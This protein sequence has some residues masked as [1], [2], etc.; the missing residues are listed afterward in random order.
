MYMY[1]TKI[2]AFIYTYW[3][4]GPANLL[5]SWH[6]HLLVGG[7]EQLGHEAE[8]SCGGEQ[9]V[10]F[11]LPYFF[12]MQCFIKKWI[13]LCFGIETEE[14]PYSPTFDIQN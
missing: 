9:C 11:S 2:N 4:W 7:G 12:M 5:S 1:N 6:Q 13:T 10:A 14:I 8:Y 3:F